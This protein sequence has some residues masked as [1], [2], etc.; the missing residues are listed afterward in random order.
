MHEN[1]RARSVAAVN[2]CIQ[3]TLHAVHGL[4]LLRGIFDDPVGQAVLRLLQRLVALNLADL[5]DLADLDAA[6]IAAAYSHAFTE[7]AV[8]VQ[9]EEAAFLPDA[10][11]AY[12][13]S[14]L[15]DHDNPWSR[16]VERYGSAR[17]PVALRQQA[18]RDLRVLQQLFQI[19][20]DTFLR[21]TQER[22]STVMPVLHDAWIPWRNLG[23]ATETEAA[24]ARG[25]LEQHIAACEDW[26]TLVGSLEEHWARHGAGPLA[27]YH[28]LR[29]LGSSQRLQ[30]IAHPDSVQLAN[31]IGYGR[32]QARLRA[33]TERF[34][35]GLPAHDALLYG[36]PGT[37]KSSTVKA[38]VNTYADEGLCLVE[39]RKEYL[40]DLPQIVSQLRDR[41]PRFLLF[42]DDLSFE[43]HE[44]EY[45][46]LKMLLEGTAEA[47]P[48]N[49][50]VYATTNRMNLV[51]EY[52]TDRGK[53]TE[54]VNW[55]D[56]MEEKQSLAHRFGLRVTFMS[57][58][59]EHYLNIVLGLARQR[60]ITLSEEVLRERALHWERQHVG[61]SGRVARQF[62]DELEAESK[63][64]QL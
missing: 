23:I 20:A 8:F 19:T 57:P 29:W 32:E 49:V 11:Q 50:L 60:G 51:R 39:V 46:V 36:P 37:G 42:I 6:E 2:E 40:G 52:F 35:A 56:T 1:G 48:A 54:D 24:P 47:R 10:W 59:Q 44:V 14:Q 41:A 28:V 45:K 63:K 7:L 30:G 31:L 21:L 9:N 55:R 26:A 17:I 62:V 13:V 33:N 5:A 22:V 4:T 64:E 53:P 43:E 25:A 3:T 18:E 15:L 61:R 16:L 27:H 58:D 38:L 34:L 12:L